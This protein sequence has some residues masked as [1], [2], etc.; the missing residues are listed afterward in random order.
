M[1]ILL[2]MVHTPFSEIV[3]GGCFGK[4]PDVQVVKV[5]YLKDV[6]PLQTLSNSPID[7]NQIEY[8]LVEANYGAP[9]SPE[10]NTELLN[11]FLANCPRARI[12]AYSGTTECLAQALRLSERIWVM[13]KNNNFDQDTANICKLLEQQPQNIA[14]TSRIFTTAKLKEMIVQSRIR[15]RAATLPEVPVPID[16]KTRPRQN[17]ISDFTPYYTDAVTLPKKDQEKGTVELKVKTKL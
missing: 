1:S 16:V 8:V 17:T 15:Q 11:F 3:L 12:I 7:Y 14:I 2:V 5:P 9:A 13:D 10:V 6:S 4:I